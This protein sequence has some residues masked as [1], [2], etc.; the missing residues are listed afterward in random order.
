MLLQ[1][2]YWNFLMTPPFRL[3][4]LDNDYY[5]HALLETAKE[6]SPYTIFGVSFMQRQRFTPYLGTSLA[7]SLL[8][9]TAC[10]PKTDS[11]PGT[12]TDDGTH[13]VEKT[14]NVS[15]AL[16]G[17]TLTITAK[18]GDA[19]VMTDAW[20]YTLHAG[21]LT[22]F[23]D[24]KD[25]DSKRRY[26][27]LMLP[28]TVG[29]TATQFTPCDDGV[30]NG[31][32]TDSVVDTLVA[33]TQT[34]KSAI[35]GTVAV[36][37]NSV[38]TD[39]IVVVVARED[40]RYAGAAAITPDGQPATVPDGVGAPETHDKVTYADIKPIIDA[41]CLACHTKGNT[42]AGGYPLDSYD[43]IVHNNFAYGEQVTQCN[44]ATPGN[45]TAID[46]C[47]AKI[48]KTEYM[49]D[50]G[51]PA[52]STQLVRT[53]PDEQ[54]SVS[55]TG[56]LWYGSKGSRFGSTGDRRMPSLNLTADT[57]DDKP[58]PTYFDQHTADYKKLWDWVAQ[59]ALP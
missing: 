40:Q 56:L 38:P 35:D 27:G 25:P 57:S 13:L 37:L 46:A 6:G 1:L 48:T 3:F 58:L 19:P 15:L 10:G 12:T 53:R 20:L 18:D 24:F 29:A 9:L 21:T 36:P 28:C 17:T 26:R 39:P 43:N 52:L 51:N 30:L 31:V 45:Q 5:F 23:T 47:V 44:S 33:G 4:D 55:P 14:L 59:G 41:N 16:S 49:V 54:Q 2:K 50:P 7:A 42:I 8:W 22:P 32:M 34:T 11:N